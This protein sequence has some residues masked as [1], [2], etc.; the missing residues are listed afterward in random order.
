[1]ELQQSGSARIHGLFTSRITRARNNAFSLTGLSF[2]KLTTTPRDAPYAPSFVMLSA[3]RPA[4]GPG[5][6]GGLLTRTPGDP[7]LA[8]TSIHFLRASIAFD[9]TASSGS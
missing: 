6:A 2:S 4:S 8:A 9:R 3:I 5:F 7:I 1:M